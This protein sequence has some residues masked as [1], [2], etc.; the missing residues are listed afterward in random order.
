[1][2]ILST[3]AS[4]DVGGPCK[5]KDNNLYY[6]FENGVK[7]TPQPIWRALPSTLGGESDDNLVDLTYKISG[8][9][10]SVW[11][12]TTPQA[13]SY[14]AAFLPTALTN[15]T[16][17]G[18]PLLGA[19][20]NVVNIISTNA[21]GFDFKRCVLTK[22]PTV[23]YGLG[24]PLWGEVEWTGF[25]QNGFALNDAA[26]FYA[27][28]TT[29]WAQ[30]DYPVDHQEQIAQLIWGAVSGWTSVFA[31]EGFSHTHESKLQ[32]VKQG[33]VTVDMKVLGYRAML[34]FKPQQPTTT[35]LLA[36]LALQGAGGG[37]GTRRSANA[38][39]AVISLDG[40]TAFITLKAMGLRTGVFEFDNKL[41]R[42]GDFTLVTAQQTPG[43]R[44]VIA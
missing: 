13:V 25:W 12:A 30:T 40:S 11:K 44:I 16:Y 8:T 35:Q 24:K 43:N 7:I 9:P 41:N 37:I 36:A 6:Y 26:A 2:S 33:N 14:A 21:K 42:H 18:V 32:P 19:T 22:M 1:M 39:D 15:F 20:N 5:I 17:T 29:A 34:A 27:E 4:I 3:Y 28:N 23:Y 38:N 31:E 10:K